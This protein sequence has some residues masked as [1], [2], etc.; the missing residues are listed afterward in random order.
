MFVFYSCKT[1]HALDQKVFV[2]DRRDGESQQLF[3]NRVRVAVMIDHGSFGC[4]ENVVSVKIPVSDAP[5]KQ[6][7]CNEN[8]QARKRTE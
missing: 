8:C 2:P 1:C 4:P 7:P 5:P 6:E 3:T